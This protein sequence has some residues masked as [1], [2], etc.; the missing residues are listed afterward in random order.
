[1]CQIVNVAGYFLTQY[2]LTNWYQKLGKPT[3]T[4]PDIAF[5]IVWNILYLM[6]GVAFFLVWQWGRQNRRSLVWPTTLFILQ[7]VF[8]FLWVLLFF[9]LRLPKEAMFELLVL[10]GLVGLTMHSFSHINKV[11][12][13]LMLPYFLWVGFAFVLNYEIWNINFNL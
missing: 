2:S 8:N 3:Y 13:Y 7:L 1:M 12:A 10:F 5:P 4:P 9:G 6:M 11:A